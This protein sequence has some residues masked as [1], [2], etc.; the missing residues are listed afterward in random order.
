MSAEQTRNSSKSFSRDDTHRTS[1]KEKAT[2]SINADRSLQ[3][4]GRGADEE[5][6]NRADQPIGE[7]SDW[8]NQR[9]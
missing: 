3:K 6:I 8:N 4:P 9:S 2:K 7:F 1:K 5:K